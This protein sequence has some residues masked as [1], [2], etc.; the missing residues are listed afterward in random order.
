MGWPIPSAMAICTVHAC[1]YN[2]VSDRQLIGL[3][4]TEAVR[5]GVRFAV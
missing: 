1:Y 4:R 3:I 2:G 5:A